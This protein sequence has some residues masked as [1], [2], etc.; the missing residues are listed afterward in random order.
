MKY[1]LKYVELL[2]VSAYLKEHGKQYEKAF[3][4]VKENDYDITYFIDFCLDSMISAL[5][6]VDK[7]VNYLVRMI[8]LKERF[9]LNDNQVGLMQRMALNKF[10]TVDIEEY[11][12][13]IEMSRESSRKELKQLHD[14][15]LL[16]EIKLG[17]KL[18]YKVNAKKLRKLY[19][20]P[21]QSEESDFLK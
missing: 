15:G 11:A 21:S 8:D 7:K 14:L 19:S 13:Q 20:E 17:K 3:I 9:S 12:N 10:R 5:N 2:S 6:Q 16:E 18:I 1:K 4:K